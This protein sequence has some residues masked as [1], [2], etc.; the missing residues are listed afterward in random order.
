MKILAKSALRGTQPEIRRGLAVDGIELVFLGGEIDRYQQTRDEVI[1]VAEY[2]AAIGLEAPCEEQ[3]RLISPLSDNHLIAATSKDYLQRCVELIN[4]VHHQTGREAYFQYQ[5][6]FAAFNERGKPLSRYPRDELVRKA[7]DFHAQL[8]K[9][10]DVP[11]QVESA[12]PICIRGG[13]PAYVPIMTRGED[14]TDGQISI[15]LDIAHLGITFYTWSKAQQQQDDLYLIES[16]RGRLW[17]EMADKD[18]QIG[19]RI[20]HSSSLQDAITAEIIGFIKEY[21][22]LIGSLQ[23]S[24]AKAGVGTDDGDEGYAGEDGLLDV[25]RIFREAII[26]ANISYVIPEYQETNYLNPVQ[27]QK[28]IAMVRGLQRT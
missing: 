16:P 27:Q 25:P 28:A 23:F 1:H 18:H 11:L 15:A 20:K 26:P 14:F 5:H 19:S 6:S 3:G 21:S 9:D 4:E 13:K 12:T 22:G 7:S 17:V 10:S 8:Q 24:N 2:F